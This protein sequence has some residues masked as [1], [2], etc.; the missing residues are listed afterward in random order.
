MV[1]L[2]CVWCLQLHAV[3]LKQFCFVSYCNTLVVM[4][5]FEGLGASVR[6][7]G[8]I[9]VCEQRGSY[10]SSLQTVTSR[11]SSSLPPRVPRACRSGGFYACVFV[12]RAPPTT[13]LWLSFR[14]RCRRKALD[15][16][17]CLWHDTWRRGS[18]HNKQALTLTIYIL[19]AV[20][21]KYALQQPQHRTTQLRT[22]ILSCFCARQKQSHTL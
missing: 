14:G 6:W 10:A 9:C 2:A 12:S 20:R 19:S 7:A 17:Q 5:M 13:Q 4:I 1:S 11:S 18:C 16:W 8:A 15:K 3:R 21:V 22:F